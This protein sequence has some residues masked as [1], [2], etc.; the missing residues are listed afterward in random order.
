MTKRRCGPAVLRRKLRPQRFSPIPTG[1]N[2]GRAPA[3]A[4]RR[5][6]TSSGSP[7]QCNR[8][9]RGR[10]HDLACDALV[11]NG[12]VRQGGELTI[13]FG[14]EAVAGDARSGY[15]SGRGD[16]RDR[17]TGCPRASRIAPALARC[18]GCQV[19]VCTGYAVRRASSAASSGVGRS[20]SG[21]A[22]CSHSLNSGST[23]Y[24]LPSR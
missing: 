13:A 12:V 2:D 17:R 10:T 7:A 18:T 1:T 14:A 21:D 23:M 4:P 24:Q 16:C 20:M 3:L 11:A 19:H 8:D 5:S 6:P 9:P 22:L 15:E